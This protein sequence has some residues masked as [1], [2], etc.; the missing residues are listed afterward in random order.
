MVL[1]NSVDEES[2]VV[3]LRLAQ[4]TFFMTGSDIVLFGFETDPSTISDGIGIPYN[5][6]TDDAIVPEST[7]VR[8]VPMASTM[9]LV[10]IGC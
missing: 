8:G 3:L 4:V 7:I 10:T 5:N 6:P 1:A 9:D 2:P